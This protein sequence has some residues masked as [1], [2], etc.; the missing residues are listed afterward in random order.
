MRTP[1]F[2]IHHHGQPDVLT[3]GEVDLPPPA[4]SEIQIRQTAIGINFAD[5]YQRRGSTGPHSTDVFPAVLGSQGAG[6]VTRVGTSVRDINVGQRVAYI[7]PGAYQMARNVQAERTV[8]LPDDVSDEI[9]AACLLRGLTAEYLLHRLPGRTETQTV[10]VH[11]AAGGMGSILCQWAASLGMT[12]IGTVGSEAKRTAARTF[13]CHQV[14][15]YRLEDFVQ[16]TLAYTEGRGVDVVFDAVG[17]DVFV[18]SLA[19]LRPMGLAVNYGTASGDVTDLD[20][21]L[22]HKNSLV[23]TRPT[24]RTFITNA[25]ELREAASRFFDALACGCILP[26]IG[27]RYAFAD[28]PSA[29]ADLESRST[30]GTIIA[31]V[32]S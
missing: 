7:Q 28:I 21:G 24:L 8:C 25:C 2:L 16:A 27:H 12:V 11:A 5:I 23:V 13:G 9:A 26:S 32:P 30:T 31:L 20:L 6:V 10:L 15:N 14:I 17:K 29:H 3:A 19:C 4:P 1:A 18:P 22:L